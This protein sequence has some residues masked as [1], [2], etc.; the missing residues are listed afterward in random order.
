[1]A[2]MITEIKSAKAIPVVL[3][4]FPVMDLWSNYIG[5]QLS[6]DVEALSKTLGF[7]IVNTRRVL[8]KYPVHTIFLNDG[9]HLT[10]FAHSLVAAEL[11]Q[12]ISKTEQLWQ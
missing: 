2:D 12:T 8:E 11:A 9:I 7:P 3:T 10:T 6:A 4:P 1:M 5:K